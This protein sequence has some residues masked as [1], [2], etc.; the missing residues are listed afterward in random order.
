VLPGEPEDGLTLSDAT[1]LNDAVAVFPFD[2]VAVKTWGPKPA[3]GI[4]YLHENVPFDKEV[5]E[6]AAP[7]LQVTLTTVEWG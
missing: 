3:A 5:A 7:L 1:T 2:A 6:H 4:A